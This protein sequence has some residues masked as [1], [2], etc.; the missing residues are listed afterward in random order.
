MLNKQEFDR[1]KK[2]LNNF[3]EKREKT[4][5]ASRE[6]IK[7]SKLIIY[8]AQRDDLKTSLSYINKIKESIKQI[9]NNPYDT[10][11]CNVAR[12]E[13]VEAIAYYEFVKTNK[14][15]SMNSLKVDHESYL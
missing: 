7:L 9:P 2:T 4:I 10:N 5:Q 3:E 14:I 11:I 1:I 13:F 12:Q 8:S 15:P 6:V